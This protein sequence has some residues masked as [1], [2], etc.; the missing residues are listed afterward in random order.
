MNRPQ[1]DFLGSTWPAWLLCLALPLPPLILWR[2]HDGRFIALCCFFVG[3]AT[4][5]V[6]SFRGDLAGA[7]GPLPLGDLRTPAELWRKRMLAIG[8]ALL[9]EWIAFSASCLLLNDRNDLVAPALAFLALIPASCI[10]PYLTLTTGKPFAAVVLTAFSVGCMKL[11]A[12]GVTCLVYGWHARANRSHRHDMDPPQPD[13]LGIWLCGLR[14]F[15]VVLHLWRKK[16]QVYICR[17][18]QTRRLTP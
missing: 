15:G 3:C 1:R 18:R 11:V 4:A 8:L 17:C 7:N 10:A 14:A 5:V 6:W 9:A 16:I 13:R 2:S 12:G